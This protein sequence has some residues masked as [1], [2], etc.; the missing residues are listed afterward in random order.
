[1]FTYY[2]R[3]VSDN[4]DIVLS[5]ESI[6]LAEYNVSFMENGSIQAKKKESVVD[7]LSNPNNISLRF[8]QVLECKIN[9]TGINQG[10]KYN[11]ILRKLYETID[12]GAKIIRNTKLN[13]Q[14]IKTQDKGFYYIEKLNISVQSVDADKACVEII[15]QA[16]QNDIAIKMKVR[17][18]DVSVIIV[19]SLE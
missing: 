17:L 10:L 5:A 13:I 11:T 7:I 9:G 18:A 2:V 4:G 16:R 19:S 14:T 6:S 15:H 12:D 1:M 3:S 8:S